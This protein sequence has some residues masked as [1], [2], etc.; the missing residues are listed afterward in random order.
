MA[1]TEV[2]LSA[3]NCETDNLNKQVIFIFSVY[4]CCKKDVSKVS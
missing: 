1:H 4:I 2:P 3:P